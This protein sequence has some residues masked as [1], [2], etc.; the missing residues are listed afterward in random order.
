MTPSASSMSPTSSVRTAAI[1]ADEGRAASGA[2]KSTSGC[3]ET[4]L[5]R[6]SRRV[7]WSPTSA[8]SA[9]I[10][11]ESEASF[12]R[13]ATQKAPE[14]SAE[15]SSVSSRKAGSRPASRGRSRSSRAQNEWIVPMKSW[16]SEAYASPSRRASS[17]EGPG[18]SPAPLSSR[19]SR[20]WKR[21]LSSPAALRVNV[22]AAISDV[23]ARPVRMRASMRRTSERVLPDPAP[24]STRMFASRSVSIA[25]LAAS[26]ARR[27][28]PPPPLAPA[29]S[30]PPLTARS[31]SSARGA[32]SG[33]P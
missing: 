23:V 31:P 19:S 3:T 15:A 13:W 32:G 6:P 7:G 17:S 2:G 8:S 12:S 10:G 5:N 28:S 22:T 24:A 20:T 16:S 1:S 29:P 26:S 25:V 27:G 11:A 30:G 18:G 21:S 9:R 14:S 33:T 4:S